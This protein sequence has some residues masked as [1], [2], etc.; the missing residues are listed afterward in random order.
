M[1]GDLAHLSLV[2]AAEQ[3]ASQATSLGMALL[4]SLFFC[5]PEKGVIIIPQFCA[6]R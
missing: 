2:P 1:Q 4:L 6:V 3:P 5:S